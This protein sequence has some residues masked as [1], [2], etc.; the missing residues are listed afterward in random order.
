MCSKFRYNNSLV[1]KNT[2]I[3]SWKYICICEQVI[4]LRF[5]C[6]KITSG[7]ISISPPNLPDVNLMKYQARCW[8]C[9]RWLMLPSWRLFCWRYTWS[10]STG[11]LYNFV[12]DFDH[13]L[14]QLVDILN[15]LLNISLLSGQLTFATETFELL[16]ESC[17]ESTHYSWIPVCNCLFTWRI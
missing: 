4:K 9:Q 2:T 12:A 5:W 17:A 15:A 1:L 6:K 11:Q 3:W 13:A 16:T 8:K 10:S 7:N 14:R